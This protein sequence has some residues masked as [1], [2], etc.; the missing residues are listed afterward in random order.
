VSRWPN[1]GEWRE[2]F[3]AALQAG[4]SIAAAARLAH[5]SK[6]H[7]YKVRRTD[8]QF[9]AAW[10]EILA[11]R[12]EVCRQC[13]S[14]DLYTT[15]D[16]RKQCRA[17]KRRAVARYK[18]AHPE[19]NRE[20]AR[21]YYARNRERQSEVNRA[22]VQ[23]QPAERL[24]S[25]KQRYANTPRGRAKRHAHNLRRRQAVG[26]LP[27]RWAAHLRNDP[28]AYCG[29]AGGE[30]D[31]I[32]PVAAGGTSGFENLI[33]ACRRCN[34]QKHTVPLLSFLLARAA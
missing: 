24:A 9:R 1:E 25:Y 28:C 7:V 13:G 20:W 10:E 34:A 30:V 29:G 17:C 14:D 11:T 2:P 18:R 23:R 16:G 21:G 8:E 4:K 6:V 5:V 27:W 19:R 33:G 31:H 32:V 12:P 26:N 22:W 15:P 3:F